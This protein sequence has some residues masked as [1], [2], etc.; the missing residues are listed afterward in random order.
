M[1]GPRDAGVRRPVGPARLALLLLA[2]ALLA[3]SACGKMPRVIVL[4]D[5]LTAEE[6]VELGVAYEHKG[7]LDAAI[8]EYEKALRKNGELFQARVNLGNARLAKREY[9]KARE[10][11]RRA[12]AIRPA[13]PEATNNLAWAA[14]LSGKDREDAAAKMEAVISRPAN[15]KPQFLDT[16][17]VLQNVMGKPAAADH[18]FA[19]AER[20]CL[21]QGASACPPDVLGEIRLHRA[22]GSAP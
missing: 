12:L 17:G 8:R 13:D 18:A 4:N 2:W 7:E 20:I 19:E 14:I 10:E 22:G 21:A 3:V 6:H 16:W 11:Y 1:S 5:P 15:R 9:D